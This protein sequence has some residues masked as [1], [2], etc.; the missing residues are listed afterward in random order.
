MFYLDYD[1]WLNHSKELMDDVGDWTLL[2]TNIF[3]D[4]AATW[5]LNCKSIETIFLAFKSS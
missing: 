3:N 1:L 4:F 5:T 2:N